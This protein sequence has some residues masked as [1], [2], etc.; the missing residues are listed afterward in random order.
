MQSL[1]EDELSHEDYLKCLKHEQDRN[2]SFLRAEFERKT[3]EVHKKFERRMK[4]T[5]TCQ[6]KKEF[7]HK[8]CRGSGKR[9][10]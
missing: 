2:I 5:S 1:K 8:S 7:V 9:C 4:G 6:K 3:S 10:S